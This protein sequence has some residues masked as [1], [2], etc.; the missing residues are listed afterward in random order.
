MI[1]TSVRE[2]V[3]GDAVRVHQLANGMTLLME[4]MPH[5]RSA[6]FTLMLPAGTVDESSDKTGLAAISMEMM[7]RGA[8]K[9]SSRQIIEDLDFLGAD[10]DSTMSLLFSTFSSAMIDAYL[11][12][13]L[14]IYADIVRRPHLDESQLEDSRATALQELAALQDEPM[15]RCLLKLR[16]LRYGERYGR[17][18]VGTEE[19]V[20]AV[21]L[22]DVH[23]YC[24]NRL[25][26]KGTILSV[27]GHID[28]DRTIEMTEK[29]FGNWDSGEARQRHDIPA[30]AGYEHI[31]EET[32]QTQ[33]TLAYDAV[34][35]DHEKYYESRA[36]INI[37]GDGMSS[38][39][40]TEVRE[41]RGL[42]Y[43]VAA[44]PQSI[45]TRSSAFIYAGTTTARADET[46]E[47]ILQTIESLAEGINEDELR[48]LKSRV[49]SSLV[50]EQES[51]SARAA[52]N[53]ADWLYLGRIV[54]RK[55]VLTR[56]DSLTIDQ[57]KHHVAEFPPKNRTLVTLG[58]KALESF[59]AV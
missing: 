54:N 15:Q 38:R 21:T 52:Q 59:N 17:S 37:L 49:K 39:L 14:E 13:V 35:Y 50:F 45:A 8:G 43:S 18:S 25:H 36:L 29:F 32:S 55:E 4:R 48:R 22:E 57:L 44:S 58:E 24:R 28:F 42:A 51:C 31:T 46:I 1:E 3:A 2:V 19:G 23:S 30:I 5:L 10:R 11:E 34:P 6:A 47:V 40:F 33:I 9:R 53:A 16:S 41:K 27:A 7:Q 26:A 12:Q 20:N 56:V